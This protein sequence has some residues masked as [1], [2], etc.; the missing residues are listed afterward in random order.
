MII[1]KLGYLIPHHVQL[2]FDNIYMDCKRRDYKKVTENHVT[3]IYE[4]KMLSIQGHAELSHL[5]ERLKMAFG[6]EIY[7]IAL[8][9]LTEAAVRGYL[10]GKSALA[11]CQSYEIAEADPNKILRE[12]LEILQHDGYLAQD[13]ERFVFVSRLL[14]DWWKARFAF[15]YIPIFERRV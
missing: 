8:E 2:F 13:D 12:I 7:P 15:G 3:E 4:T 1:E 10:D 11:I 14:K 9:I 6:L 5:E